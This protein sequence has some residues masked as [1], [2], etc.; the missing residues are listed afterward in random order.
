MTYFVL[1]FVLVGKIR[2]DPSGTKY[3]KTLNY[4]PEPEV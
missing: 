3:T 4:F 2:G 1:Y